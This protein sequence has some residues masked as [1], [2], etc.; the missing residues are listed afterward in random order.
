MNLPN[1]ETVYVFDNQTL[2]Q[3]TYLTDIVS[4][5]NSG[6][7]IER[8]NFNLIEHTGG[9]RYIINS[10]DNLGAKVTLNGDFYAPYGNGILLIMALVARV[11]TVL[12]LLI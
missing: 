2:E 3:N 4:Y 9:S 8:L 10:G 5:T 1:H 12:W 11:I 7:E 6:T